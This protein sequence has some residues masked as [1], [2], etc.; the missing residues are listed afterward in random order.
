MK[1]KCQYDKL[2]PLT[3][4]SNHPKNRNQHSKEQITR[5]AGIFEYQGIR[6]PIIVSNLSGHI[7]AG[8]GR[9]EAAVK[10]GYKE[11][12]VNFQD[13]KDEEQEYAFLVSDNSIALWA[14]LDLS[15]IN[16]DLPD[17]GPDFD[18]DMLGI[19]DFE[20]EP[21]DKYGDKTD[22]QDNDV[23]ET[24]IEAKTKLGDLYQ[25]GDHRL[26]CGDATDNVCIGILLAETKVDM[27]FTDPPYNIGFKYESYDDNKTNEEYSAF[28]SL[29][30]HAL[31][32]VSSKLIITPGINNIALWCNILSPTHIGCWVKK[33][34]ISSCTISNLQQWE[35]VLFYGKFDRNSRS[36]DLFEINR[37]YQKDVDKNHPCPKQIAFVEAVLCWAGKTVADF[38]G[39]SGTTIIACEKT[40]RK[41][42]MMELEPK[43]CDVIISRWEKYTDKKAELLQSDKN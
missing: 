36:S 23:P 17:L 38:F 26:L 27:V 7:V 3:D 39:G 31:K 30:F 34:W 2:I 9:L 20:L 40:N 18:I 10:N 8:H 12:P 19:K 32:N 4:F 6:H 37:V 28:C 15:G 13:F 5:L 29:W 42:Y 33:N 14:E 1:I 43:Y 24:P 22:E 21:A 11:F 41:C 16:I 35:P 25:L